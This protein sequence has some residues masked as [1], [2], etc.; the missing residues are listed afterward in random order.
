M[1]GLREKRSKTCRTAILNMGLVIWV[2][3]FIIKIIIKQY[4]LGCECVLSE[5]RMKTRQS[6]IKHQKNATVYHL[7]RHLTRQWAH[8]FSPLPLLLTPNIQVWPIQV[9][10]TTLSNVIGFPQKQKE[11]NNIF[12]RQLLCEC[13]K[14]I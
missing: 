7:T 4:E 5:S 1:I 11:R 6:A 12:G 13:L 10:N 8:F 3:C 9:N 2:N 14:F